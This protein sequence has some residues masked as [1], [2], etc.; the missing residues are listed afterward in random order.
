MI[1]DFGGVLII[2]ECGGVDK[3][4]NLFAG[5]G[6]GVSGKAADLEAVPGEGWRKSRGGEPARRQGTEKRRGMREPPRGY[7]EIIAYIDY[8]VKG[9][10]GEFSV[11]RFKF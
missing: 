6:L 8:G 11:F 2:F 1:K 10:G 4:L 3:W 5:R 9:E 7:V